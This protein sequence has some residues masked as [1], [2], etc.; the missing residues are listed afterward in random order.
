MKRKLLVILFSIL[1]MVTAVFGLTACGDTSSS[2][3]CEHNFTV[4]R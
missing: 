4:V 2:D 1:A 3:N